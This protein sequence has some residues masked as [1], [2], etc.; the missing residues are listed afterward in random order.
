MNNPTAHLQ[1]WISTTENSRERIEGLQAGNGKYISSLSFFRDGTDM[2]Y[3][4]KSGYALIGHANITVDLLQTQ[5]IVAA[6]VDAL[7]E[8]QKVMRAEAHKK[9]VQL[10]GLI[11][12]LLAIDHK[13]VETVV[14]D[15]DIEE[16]D[17]P[18]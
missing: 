17:F 18:F 12:S 1:A 7:R 16:D 14:R 10:E 9:D 13:P 5:E 6:Q 2:S 15:F 3:W 4:I 11:Q 8:Q